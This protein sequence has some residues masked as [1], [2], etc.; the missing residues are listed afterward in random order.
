[1]ECSN[2]EAKPDI[3]NQ[4]RVIAE[5]VTLYLQRATYLILPSAVLCTSLRHQTCMTAES[6]SSR[7]AAYII[8]PMQYQALLQYTYP[9]I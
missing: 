8:S 4:P 3:N 6:V 5:S 7:S 9:T 2:K 1:M